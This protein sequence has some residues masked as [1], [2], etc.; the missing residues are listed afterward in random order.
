MEDMT[1]VLI[2]GGIA[3]LAIF[4]F[5]MVGSKPASSS[6]PNPSGTTGAPQTTSKPAETITTGGTKSVSS[7]PSTYYPMTNS[8][9]VNLPHSGGQLDP[10]LVA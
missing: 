5:V 6:V 3:I 8:I 1:A 10:K 9:N 2:V 4:L 7:P